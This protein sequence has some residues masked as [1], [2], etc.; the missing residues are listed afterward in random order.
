MQ[1][2][3]ASILEAFPA[4]AEIKSFPAYVL[5]YM[6]P[7]GSMCLEDGL[8]FRRVMGLLEEEKT[9]I[10]F[11]KLEELVKHL[12]LFSKGSCLSTH[13]P[14]WDPATYRADSEV[15]YYPKAPKGFPLEKLHHLV[16]DG[17]SEKIQ[18]YDELLKENGTWFR[19][20]DTGMIPKEDQDKLFIVVSKVNYGTKGDFLKAWLK[21]TSGF[22]DKEGNA[23]GSE[24]VY[25]VRVHN[26]FLSYMPFVR[27]NRR[28]A[29][30][31][32]CHTLLKKGLYPPMFW[33]R[34]SYE[35]KLSVLRH[36]EHSTAEMSTEPV[37]YGQYQAKVQSDFKEFLSLILSLV[38]ESTSLCTKTMPVDEKIRELWEE[39]AIRGNL[40]KAFEVIISS[41]KRVT[42]QELITS[43]SV[44]MKYNGKDSIQLEDGTC[45]WRGISTEIK[46]AVEKL[47]S[48][49]KIKYGYAER[50]EYES[51]NWLPPKVSGTEA[52]V[53]RPVALVPAN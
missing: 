28:L 43:A 41:R 4:Q 25:A 15:Y 53:W 42:F 17:N 20:I 35:S 22:F 46:D 36:I 44:F 40:E 18:K 3:T 24:I 11:N 1:P 37:P 38:V 27:G 2:S 9:V 47:V 5:T 26:L 33:G 49:G 31:L 34:A 10:S 8:G 39:Y 50:Q 16:F 19:V 6:T 45:I 30:L 21:L 7:G 14:D 51:C 29:R 13:S 48:N 52:L 12:L 32:L 23:T